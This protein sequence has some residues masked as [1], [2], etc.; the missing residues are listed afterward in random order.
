MPRVLAIALSLLV[1]PVLAAPA[2]AARWPGATV[3]Y[4]NQTAFPLEVRRAVALWNA[5]VTRPHLVP[6]RAGARAQIRVIPKSGPS[7]G[8]GSGAFGYYPPDGRIFMGRSWA[9]RGA[10]ID[11]P[12]DFG[13]VNLVAHEL[14]HA[15]GLPHAAGCRLMAASSIPSSGLA[16]GPCPEAYRRMPLEWD[17]CGPQT[18]DARALAR[19]YGG[20]VRRHARFGICGPPPRRLPPA[21][22][23]VFATPPS[24]LWITPRGRESGATTISVRNTGPWVWG[25]ATRGSFGHSRDD[26]ELRMLEPSPYTDCGPLD[27]PPAFGT[28]FPTDATALARE[29]TAAEQVRPGGT[30]TFRLELCPD[31]SG[32]PRTIKLQLRS[33]SSGGTRTGPSL[34][35]VV[36]RDSPP[37]PEIAWAA[38]DDPIAAG[39]P[40]RFTDRSTADRGIAS[41]TWTF[42]DPASGAADGS[43]ESDPT[44][45]FAAEGG[46]EVTLTVT[47]TT[48]R[49]ASTT[50]YVAVT[51]SSP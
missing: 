9:R 12:Y 42:G 48:G 34:T 21:P 4:R 33:R 6:A 3:T 51:A 49:Q 7:G 44:H 36:R 17:F 25:R 15:L 35:L 11:D 39:M 30:G 41:R 27:L 26:V 19:L 1:L 50:T 16:A 10:R 8:E 18:G 24:P 20:R 38:A 5:A 47:D 13:P 28:R 22:V 23:A 45:T 32:T 40:V 31:P 2:Q 46:Y 43:T 29:T 37:Q 14:G